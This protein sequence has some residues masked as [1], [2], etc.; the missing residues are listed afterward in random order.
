KICH[1]YREANKAADFLAGIDL[2]FSIGCYSIP[3]SDAN[4]GYFIRYDYLG[5]NESRSND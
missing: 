5:V 1:S 3:S 4:L 2:R